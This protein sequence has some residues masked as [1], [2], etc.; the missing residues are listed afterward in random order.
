MVG[1]PIV[2]AIGEGLATSFGQYP[3]TDSQGAELFTTMFT[4]AGH[5]AGVSF[6]AEAYDAAALML[7]AMQAAGSSASADWTTRVMDVANAPG[8]PILPGELPKALELLAAGTDID[9][10]GATAVELIGSGESA[11]SYREID[12][13]NGQINTVQFR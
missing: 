8:E 7:L 10:E 12:F 3:G 1:P 11:G 6:T 4:E 13:Q 2:E 9:Y 5:D